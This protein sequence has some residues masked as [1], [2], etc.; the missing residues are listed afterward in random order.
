MLN[1]SI[2]VSA[3]LHNT[4]IAE[5]VECVEGRRFSNGQLL[6]EQKYGG[7][8]ACRFAGSQAAESRLCATRAS[9]IDT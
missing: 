1:R 2:I 6:K 4:I 8:D 5:F 7:D 3:R 9:C